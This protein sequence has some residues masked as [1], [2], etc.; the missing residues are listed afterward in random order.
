MNEERKTVAQVMVTAWVDIP[1]TLS[2][3]EANRLLAATPDGWGLV[4]EG[5]FILAIIH[6]DDV[7]AWGLTERVADHKDELAPLL[8]VEA[9]LP[10]DQTTGRLARFL[11]HPAYRQTRG[12]LVE[13]S[14]KATGILPKS[15]LMAEAG[16]AILPEDIE[17]CEV[18][19]LPGPPP[20]PPDYWVCAPNE[21]HN[22]PIYTLMPGHYT[23][24]PICKVCG[25]PMQREE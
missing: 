9:T 1:T 14:G 15:V 22:K 17:R 2:V 23:S 3:A 12:V 21:K 19:P 4:T 8:S 16:R 11:R 6:A 24:A 20:T 10:L 18:K 7:A 25:Q 5:D 13:A